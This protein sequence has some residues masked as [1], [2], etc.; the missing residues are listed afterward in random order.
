MRY[1]IDDLNSPPPYQFDQNLLSASVNGTI[2]REQALTASH[3]YILRANIINVFR[4]T[5]NRSADIRASDDTF[6]LCSLGAQLYCG[7]S[8]PSG[9]GGWANVEKI[10]VTG[11]IA[12]NSSAGPTLTREGGISDDVSWTHGNHQISF[13]TA[14]AY[15]ATNWTG[16][17]N[18][19]PTI[20]V[21]GQTTGTGYSDL[22]PRGPHDCSPQSDEKHHQQL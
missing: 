4:A 12:A 13:G 9:V 3:T 21:T 10:A 15:W 17:I 1:L 22:M 7:F 6:N 19:S 5:M 20:S 11:G 18:C 2:G 14:L 8:S 16:C